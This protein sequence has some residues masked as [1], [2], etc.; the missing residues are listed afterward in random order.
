MWWGGLHTYCEYTKE[1]RIILFKRVASVV[2]EFYL[3]QTFKK[4]ILKT[5]KESMKGFQADDGHMVK[6]DAGDYVSSG[7]KRMKNRA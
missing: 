1:S 2:Y 4:S 3:S 5:L 6:N 7:W